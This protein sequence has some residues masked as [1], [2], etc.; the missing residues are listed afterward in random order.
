MRKALLVLL[1]IPLMVYA[2]P[3]TL[4]V[5]LCNYKLCYT[6][7]VD[8]VIKYDKL[9]DMNGKPFIRFFQ[10]DGRMTDIR[11]DGFEVKIK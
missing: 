9:E 7:I 4:K 8:K 11:T 6:N 5:E 1:F 3:K 2:A 10:A